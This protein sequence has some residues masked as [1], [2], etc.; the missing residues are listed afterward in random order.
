MLDLI[1]YEWNY[2]SGINFIKTHIMI[3]RMQYWEHIYLFTQCESQ[4]INDI[5]GRHK[6][7]RSDVIEVKIHCHVAHA[8]Q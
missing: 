1:L 6:K 3:Q 7:V 5:I 8:E 2:F 4:T